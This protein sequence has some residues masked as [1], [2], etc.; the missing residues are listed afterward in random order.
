MAAMRI[1]VSHSTGDN[2]FARQL[3]KTLRNAGVDVWYNG[4]LLAGGDQWMRAIHRE[5]VER[6]VFILVVSPEATRNR[7]IKDEIDLAVSL[8]GK[9][10][11]RIILPVE[12]SPT[13]PDDI[14]RLSPVLLSRRL[15]T[16]NNL[17]EMLRNVLNELGLLSPSNENSLPA[18]KS[19]EELINLGKGLLEQNEFDEAIVFLDAALALAPHDASALSS[20]AR[21]LEG[22]GSFAEALANYRA[23]LEV[24]PLITEA[25]LNMGKIYLSQKQYEEA[26]ETF[27]TALKQEEEERAVK[28]ASGKVPAA[29][30]G[31]INLYIVTLWYHKG[32]VLRKLGRYAEAQQAYERALTIDP[33]LHMR[34]PQMRHVRL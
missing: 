5:I 2:D 30:A 15:V 10:K 25:R 17:G 6:P 20:K 11:T 1:F 16:G 32:I 14:G 3:V 24:D 26:L 4:T 22:K 23:A 28:A 19:K 9:D 13:R 34:N 18:P 27:D 31:K 12:A 7:W 29:Q 33:Q 8:S 21:A